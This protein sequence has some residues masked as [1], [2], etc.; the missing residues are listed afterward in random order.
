MLRRHKM[1][2]PITWE[3]VEAPANQTLSAGYVHDGV[4]SS[5]TVGAASTDGSIPESL[6]EQV[7]NAIK[8]LEKVLKAGNSSFEN[9]FKVIIFIGHSQYRT[10][11]NEIYKKYFTTQPARICY[12]VEFMDPTIKVEIEVVATLNN[13]PPAIK[14]PWDKISEKASSPILSPAFIH[15]DL[16]HT[17]G[18]VG[19][20]YETGIK[21]I[22]A[23]D[24]A[25]ECCKNVVKILENSNSSIDNVIKVN[26]FLSHASFSPKVNE[27][28]SKY[29]NNSPAR[30][31][32]V[33]GFPDPDLKV[34]I[35]VV[36]TTNDA[37]KPNKITWESI[38]AHHIDLLAPGYKTSNRVFTSGSVGND[39]VSGEF[40][41]SIEEQVHLACQN[42]EKVLKQGGSS[43]DSVFKVLVF[44]QHSDHIGVINKIYQQYFKSKP[45][46]SCIVVEFMDPRVLFELEAIA[47]I[48]GVPS[49]L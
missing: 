18:V 11:V 44:I 13:K 15:E 46:R 34:E 31:C 49:N 24:Q 41:T 36:A 45:A 12:V 26:L 38:N 17:A 27:I 10:K 28:Y 9:I 5:G 3:Q 42:L 48:E 33:V 7:L 32:V 2:T 19:A 30:S 29:F 16:V 20:N 25:I 37:P 40:P 23:E 22:S 4:F 47:A 1:A 6:E 8:N 14:I 35:Q 43:L 21:P 39:P